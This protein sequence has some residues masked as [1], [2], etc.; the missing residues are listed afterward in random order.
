[1]PENRFERIEKHL[2]KRQYQ[3]T[4]GDWSTLYYG[5]FTDWKGK[6]RTFPLGSELK[7]ARGQLKVLEA[8]NIRKVDFD[9]EKEE[10]RK[11]ATAGMTVAEWLEQYL[12]K[13]KSKVSWRTDKMHCVNLKRLIG[14]LLLTEVNRPRLM[15]YKTRRLSEPIMRHGKPVEGTKVKGSTVNRELSFLS[16]A[17]NLAADDGL[18]EGMPKRWKR[19]KEIARDRTLTNDEYKRLLDAAPRWLQRCVVVANE[20]A[21]DRGVLITLTWESVHDGLI[22]IKRPKTG[23]KQRI[24]ISPAL[25]EVLEELR[26]EFRRTPNTE[27]R[28]LTKDGQPIG[29]VSLRRAFDRAVSNAGIEDFQLRDFRHCARTRWAADGLS[30]E[31]AEGALGHKLPGMHGRYT[32]L[33]DD[34]VR[35]AF[36]EMSTRCTHRNRVD[37]DK[38]I[39]Y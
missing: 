18:C 3:T 14:A 1:M 29:D 19:E 15:E 20:T 31:V 33:T 8:D 32:N 13:T 26:A 30:Y 12:E 24:G 38:S 22:S 35:E 10:R 23:E 36:Q 25:R 27:R 2:Y 11:A 17:L 4:S 5:I 7:T 6:R 39:S 37:R 34:Q 21:L 16:A 28:V 9:Q